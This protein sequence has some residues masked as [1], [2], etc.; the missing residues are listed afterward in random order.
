MV[1]DSSLGASDH[2][3]DFAL[4]TFEKL[5]VYIVMIYINREIYWW[6]EGLKL[7]ESL[8]VELIKVCCDGLDTWKE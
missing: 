3:G 6:E 1:V 2:I 4:F 5:H 8:R 7:K